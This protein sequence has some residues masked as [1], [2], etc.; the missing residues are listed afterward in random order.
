MGINERG[1]YSCWR[2]SEH[3]GTDVRY[4]FT[5]LLDCSLKEV[6][7]ILDINNKQVSTNDELMDL[8]NETFSTIQIEEPKKYGGKETLLLPDWFKKPSFP[9]F[10]YLFD[11]GFTAKES[12]IIIEKYGLLSSLVG[13]F[14]Y[15]LIFPI[16]FKKELVTWVGRHIGSHP[17]IPYLDLSIEESVRHAKF[18]LWN[19]D[20]LKGGDALF[21][22]EGLFDSLKVDFFSPKGIDATCLFTKT[23]RDVQGYLLYELSKSYNSIYILLD[24]D[25]EIEA[26][27]M[28]KDLSYI[29]NI[30]LGHLPLG[31][32]DPG[33]LNKKEVNDLVK[34]LL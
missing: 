19:Y 15:R 1:W 32:K 9:F 31:R 10:S 26:L 27:K 16:Y 3:R 25:A 5:K 33:I 30:K 18:C 29:S 34:E 17:Y 21:V 4:L 7:Y 13:D 2:S 22:T 20:S 28:V 12:N 6:E 14:K 23:I 24:S 11:R 8:F